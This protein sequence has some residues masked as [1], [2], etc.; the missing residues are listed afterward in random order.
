M[1]LKQI[2]FGLL[3]VLILLFN[4]GCLGLAAVGAGAGTVM[5]MKGDM[6]VTSKKSFEE[7]F[8][9]VDLTCKELEFT[10]S[11]TEQKAFKGT[12]VADG[13]FGRV[14]FKVSAESPELTNISIRVGAFG[15][16]GASELIHSRL[17]PKL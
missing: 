13:D 4:A 14:V 2:F 10:V 16:K 7:V 17:K 9:A 15:D 6:E 8:K 5:Y 11:K 12:I 3:L 1:I